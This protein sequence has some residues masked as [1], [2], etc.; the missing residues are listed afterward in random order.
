MQLRIILPLGNVILGVLLF[1]FGDIQVL[2]IVVG[3]GGAPEGMPDG[4]ATAK[5][6]HYALN[7]PAWAALG[8][9]RQLR[10]DPS[11]YW[12]GHDLYY[13]LAVIVISYLIGLGLDDR[14]GTRTD[15][16]VPS[17][18]RW[19]RVL[20][21]AFLLY[22]LYI[23]YRVIPEWSSL[24]SMKAGTLALLSRAPGWWFVAAGL[25]WGL[26]LVSLGLWTL[27]RPHKS[28]T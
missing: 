12:R 11:T 22:G 19:N 16:R 14:F 23:F 9:T 17:K 8:E 28:A 21:S 3:N 7:A 4:A 2:R 27:L 15:E 24:I 6:V 20:A 18:G 26:G 13:F 25:S 1:H 10:W 5:Y